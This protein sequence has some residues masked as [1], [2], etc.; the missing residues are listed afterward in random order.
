MCTLVS[1]LARSWLLILPSRLSATSLSPCLSSGSKIHH[2]PLSDLDVA[3]LF[4]PSLR[5]ASRQACRG[6]VLL[7]EDLQGRGQALAGSRWT[8]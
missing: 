2:R 8:R 4:Q 7:N 1:V 3:F 5:Q 6:L